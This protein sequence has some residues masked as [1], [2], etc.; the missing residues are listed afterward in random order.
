MQP[1]VTRKC[2]NCGAQT[3]WTTTHVEMDDGASS[4][5]VT[6]VPAM[7]CPECG[8]EYLPGLEAMALSNL[9]EEIFGV[10][11]SNRPMEVAA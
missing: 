7:V 8:E 1:T 2:T 5:R 6:G 9:A 11:R 3:R 4:I 10:L